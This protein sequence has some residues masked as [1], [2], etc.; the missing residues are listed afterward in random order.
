MK[1]DVRGFEKK[2]K[3]VVMVY[4]FSYSHGINRLEN[5]SKHTI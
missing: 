2:E 5:R 3:N 4:H 1:K